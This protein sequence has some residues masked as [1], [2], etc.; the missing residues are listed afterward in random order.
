MLVGKLY[1]TKYLFTGGTVGGG[2]YL[3]CLK[4]IYIENGVEQR[5]NVYC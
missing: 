5:K 4:F 3:F 2:F 1:I